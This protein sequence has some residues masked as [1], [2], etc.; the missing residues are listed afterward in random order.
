MKGQ[1]QNNPSRALRKRNLP[2]EE[3]LEYAKENIKQNIIINM[4]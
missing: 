1:K 3:G 2:D 4:L